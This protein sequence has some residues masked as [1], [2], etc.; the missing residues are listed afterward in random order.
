[1]VVTS[2][3]VNDITSGA[4]LSGWLRQQSA[5]RQLLRTRYDARL[6]VISG[7]PPVRAFPALPQP[8]RWHLGLRAMQFDR[9]LRAALETEPDCAYVALDVRGDIA[10]MAS[11]G[12]HPG[13]HI[14]EAWAQS[15]AGRI[16]ESRV[17]T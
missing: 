16:F 17:V 3:G 9:A 14:Y 1:M 13:P 5:L 8:L 6:Q 15:V 4:R 11:D 10:D 12:F 7:L 2:L